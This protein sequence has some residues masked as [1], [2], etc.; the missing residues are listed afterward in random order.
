MNEFLVSYNATAAPYPADRTIVDLFEAQAAR[1]PDVEA[2]RQGDRALTYAEMSR[3][4][5]RVAEHLRGLGARPERLVAV[6]FERS[7]EAVCTILGALKAGAAYV[8]MDPAYPP[9]RLAYVL[10]DIRGWNGGEAPVLVTQPDLAAR[11]PSG[12]ARLVVLDR[13][14]AGLGTAP[15]GAAEH[16]ATPRAL[17][18]VIY[19]SG[20]TGKPKGVM[21]EHRSLVNY[22]WWASTLYV[23]GDRLSWPLFTSLAFDLTVTSIFTPLV[24]GG[25]IVVYPEGAGARAAAVLDVVEDNAVDIVKLTP[26]HL[27]MISTLDLSRSR[28]RRLILGGEDLRS[29]VARAATRRF[30]HPVELYNEYGPTEATVGCMTYRFDPGRDTGASVPIGIPAANAGVYV[31]DGSLR[32]V[33]EG[34]VGEMCLAGDGL[35]RGYLNDPEMTTRKFVTAEDPRGPG[36]APLRLYRTGDL[37]RWSA[38]R[39]LEFLGR[40]D[41]QV[42][43]GGFRVELGEVEARLLEHTGVRECVVTV[44]PAV[45]PPPRGEVRHCTRC[46]VASNL[47]GTTFDD[48]GLCNWCRAYDGYKD[49]AEAYFKTAADFDAVVAAM[50]A[51][52]VGAYDCLVLYSGGKDSTYML[53][54]LHELGVKPLVF[55]LDNGFISEEAKANIRRVV[56]SLGLDLV[57][58]RTPHMNEI[59]VDSLQRFS[60]VC[61]GC[62]KTIYTLAIAT[63]REKGIRH[64]VTG[65]SR[66]QFF[67]TRLTEDVFRGGD[68]APDRIDALVLQARKAYHQ[69]E[70]AVSAHVALD[71]LHGDTGL[72][73]VEFVDFYRYFS[74]SLQELYATLHRH[75]AWSRP[76]DTGRSTNCLI[77]ELGIYLHKKQRGFHNYALPYSWDVRLGQKTR[78]E[79]MEELEDE[80]D[81]ARVRKLM[82][83][84]GYTEPQDAAADRLVAYYVGDRE[85]PAPELK[86]WLAKHLPDYMVPTHFMR[87]ER[88]PLTAN[89]KV[90]RKAL[91]APAISGR[92]REAGG[93]PPAPLSGTQERVA[94][95]WRDLLKLERV[96]AEDDFFDVGGTSLLAIQM[97][98]R[99]HE[100]FG[101]D[102]G[103]RNLFERPTIAGLAEAVEGATRS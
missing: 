61:N 81:P 17:A 45:A 46:G 40:S 90:D 54:K 6:Y 20:S 49:K 25:R 7:I 80:I 95:I 89:G 96:G 78:A 55:S 9:D 13:D 18:Y 52:R 102:V 65:L 85:L 4:G 101:V 58:G 28:I 12:A 64:I 19:T 62:F 103:L 92:A 35:A 68:F 50:K 97:I 53:Y 1:T 71:V 83:E 56:E 75:G 38:D 42:K 37:A 33:P 2:I 34:V 77:N 94:T 10:G 87:L 32:P 24:S 60:N 84:I 43:I 88:L 29:E 47:P 63:A 51:A 8:P 86:A 99:L 73:D 59:F 82:Q 67:E 16:T 22:V 14:L 21:I 76:S 39:R 5:G 3:R 36:R 93:A 23:R 48:A 66:G 31:L 44:L 69:R 98:A 74:V 30:G 91:P 100:Q 26:A 70:D 27:A 15:P 11:V 57:F 72:D 79:A 41:D